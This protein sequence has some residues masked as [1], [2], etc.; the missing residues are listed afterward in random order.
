MSAWLHIKIL[1]PILGGISNGSDR[2]LVEYISLRNPS[3]QTPWTDFLIGPVGRRGKWNAKQK[4]ADAQVG[5]KMTS[6]NG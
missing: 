4:E 1:N 3:G 2:F 6:T 5:T